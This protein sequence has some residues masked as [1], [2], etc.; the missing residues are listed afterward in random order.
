M[1]IRSQLK[2]TDSRYASSDK[3]LPGLNK[4][5]VVGD[6]FNNRRHSKEERSDVKV[7][8]SRT[9]HALNHDLQKNIKEFLGKNSKLSKLINELPL[10]ENEIHS[11][12]RTNALL[13]RKLSSYHRWLKFSEQQTNSEMEPGSEIEEDSHFLAIQQMKKD[14]EIKEIFSL[15]KEKYKAIQSHR[16]KESPNYYYLVHPETYSFN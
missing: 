15:N 5:D 1:K 7:R 8:L 14:E 13:T 9:S 11:N 2:S 3:N 12:L 4:T 16:S 6:L 10:P